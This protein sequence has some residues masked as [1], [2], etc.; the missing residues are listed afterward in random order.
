[1]FNCFIYNKF[2]IFNDKVN[3]VKHFKLP[4]SLVNRER[5]IIDICRDKSVLH[6]G[7]ADSPLTDQ[8]IINGDFL[9]QKISNIAGFCTG[10]DLDKPMIDRLRDFY[11]FKNLIVG[12][13]ENLTELGLGKFDVILAG[14]VIEHLNNPGLFFNGCRQLLKSNGV[15]LITTTNAYCFR[16]FIRIPAGYESIHP[17]HT[18]YFSHPTLENLAGRFGFIAVSKHGYSLENFSIPSI[19][20]KLSAW[21]SPNMAE[22]IV[23]VYRQG[24]NQN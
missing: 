6:I 22:G 2:I 20:D 19:I 10:I 4:R 14:E 7:C 24:E 17:D 23:H 21:I 8:R 16:R 11:G 13:A 5:F 3:A 9:H 12:N 15:L 18:Y 1:M